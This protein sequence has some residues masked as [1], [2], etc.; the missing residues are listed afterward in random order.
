MSGGITFG[1]YLKSL[2]VAKGY[3]QADFRKKLNISK[4]YLLDIQSGNSFPSSELQLRMVEIL[5]LDYESSSSF[6][7]KAAEGR[8]E[9]PTDVFKYLFQNN[10]AI[11]ELRKKM[12]G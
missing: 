8:N 2:V 1:R 7:D 9:L 11:K 10:E 3:T 4:T 12:R 6:Y 5:D